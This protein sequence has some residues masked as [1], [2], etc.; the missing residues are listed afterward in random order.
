MKIVFLFCSNYYKYKDNQ[1][2]SSIWAL[3]TGEWKHTV[4]LKCYQIFFLD[5]KWE[6]ERIRVDKRRNEER[7]NEAWEKEKREEAMYGIEQ[8]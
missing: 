2:Q 7:K 8:V 6:K 3:S 4:N 5:G 1:K